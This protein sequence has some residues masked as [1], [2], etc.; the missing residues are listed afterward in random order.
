MGVF[1]DLPIWNRNQGGIRSANANIAQATAQFSAAQNDLLRQLADALARYRSA[2]QLVEA[3]EKS[4]LP[5]S[6]QTLQLVLQGYQLGQFDLVR[7]LEAQRGIVQANLDYIEAQNSRIG[8]AADVA[9]WLQ[10]D[11]F[12]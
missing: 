6:Q 8:A 11:E 5:D 10:W 2:Q 4:I 7:L 9:N 3:F 1:F 12:P